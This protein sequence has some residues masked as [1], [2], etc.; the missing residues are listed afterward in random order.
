MEKN[1][2]IKNICRIDNDENSTHAWLATVQRKRK[3]TIKMFS[4]VAL[5][6]KKKAL[7]AAIEFK[8]KV[9]ADISEYE[10]H[11]HI[12]SILRKN[13]TS[14]IPGVGRYETIRN[15]KTG[16]RD[17]YWEAFWDDE[18]GKKR[19]RRF[20]V[21]RYGEEDAKKMAVLLR[22]EMLKKVCAAKST[23]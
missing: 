14:G 10:Y 23:S 6:G 12:R 18:N 22:E 8:N 16:R 7:K 2:K 21:A 1:K 9:L 5:G 4:D 3:I 17:A 13:N 20:N 19:G 11:I 15:V